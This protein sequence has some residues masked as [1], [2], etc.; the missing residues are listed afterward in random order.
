MLLTLHSAGYVTLEP[1][2]PPTDDT[3]ASPA[4]VA[5]VATAA[6]PAKPTLTL[7]GSV[8]TKPGAAAKAMAQTNAAPAKPALVLPPAYKATH[9][10]AT[11]ELEKLMKLRGINSLY[12]MFL[13]NQLGIASREERIQAF[14]SVM[15]MPRSLLSQV[16]VPGHDELP[17]GPLA[18][19]RLDPL[20]LQWG[21]ATAQQLV[22]SPPP[23][24]DEPPRDPR[25]VERDEFGDRIRILT[26]AEK[27]KLVFDH[28]F[29]GVGEVPITPCWAAGEVLTYEG[30]FNKYV[31]SNN[32]QKQ[33]GV[34]FRHLLR[35]IL[36][37][38]EFRQLSPPDCD[39]LA[40]RDEL[41][42]IA[43]RL[44]ATCRGVDPSSTEKA[45]E[46]ARGE[47]DA[48]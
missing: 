12:G 2:P 7:G 37:L 30:N 17:P 21:L 3:A 5:A 48:L 25:D 36:L 40:W 14:E 38:G 44:T 46:D 4:I 41:D 28:D 6:E 31:T 35:M 43:D 15:E 45:L 8:A 47:L 18:Q 32:L 22:G 39:P 34:V 23:G 20:L 19:Q 10:H 42:D 13:V 26:V 1:P 27:L 11:P 16:R 24:E 29:P 33:E 9:A